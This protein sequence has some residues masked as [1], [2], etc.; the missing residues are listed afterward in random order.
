MN[1]KIYRI[2]LVAIFLGVWVW[3][4][5]YPAVRYDWLLENCLVLIF[6]PIVYLVERRLKLSNTAWTLV[7]IYVALHLVG[8]HY[9]YSKVPFGD[10]LADWFG[11]KRNMYD[12]LLHFG[13]GLLLFYPIREVMMRMTQARGLSAYLYPW[14]VI[15]GVGALYEIGEWAVATHTSF[16][17][18]SQFIAAQGDFWDSQ[19]DMWMATLGGFIAGVATYLSSLVL[20]RSSPQRDL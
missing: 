1:S 7:L 6:I 5:W 8:S 3:S 2:I 20:S 12:R 4:G 19:K 14:L 18:A 11:E 16:R 13:S 17:V 15:C 10:T 9:T